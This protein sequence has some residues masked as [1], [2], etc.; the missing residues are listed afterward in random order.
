MLQQEGEQSPQ[1]LCREKNAGSSSSCSMLGPLA[2]PPQQRSGLPFDDKVQSGT[3]GPGRHENECV[4]AASGELASTLLLLP[5]VVLLLLQTPGWDVSI[6]RITGWKWPLEILTVPFLSRQDWT[7]RI[8]CCQ[9]WGANWGDPTGL[10]GFAGAQQ[11]A[12][13]GTGWWLQ[14]P[15][16]Q[17]HIYK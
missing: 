9:G 15:F 3:A 16:A 5:G 11:P 2:C 17:P 6:Y 10:L 14:G 7:P 13:L 8:S 4:Q 12:M 1:C